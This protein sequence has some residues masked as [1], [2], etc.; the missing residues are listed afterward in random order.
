M[1]YIPKNFKKDQQPKQ[2]QVWCITRCL[3]NKNKDMKRCSC[4]IQL[5]KQKVKRKIWNLRNLILILR[6]IWAVKPKDNNNLENK[7][8]IEVMRRHQGLD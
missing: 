2:L 1:G 5:K 8:L 3:T 4:K 6:I 7:L